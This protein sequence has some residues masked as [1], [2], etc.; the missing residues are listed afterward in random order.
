MKKSRGHCGRGERDIIKAR[1]IE[2]CCE[3]VS[4]DMAGH[5]TIQLTVA[6][7]ACIR[8]IHVQ[9]HQNP[10]RDGGPHKVPLLHKNYG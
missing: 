10:R 1:V 4:A 8:T 3:P 2:D 5:H 9:A 6:V 7:T